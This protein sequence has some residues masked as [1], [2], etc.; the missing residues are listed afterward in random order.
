MDAGWSQSAD[1]VYC[2]AALVFFD[3]AESVHVAVEPM[4]DHR[5]SSCRCDL[6]FSTRGLAGCVAVIVVVVVV[7]VVE[8]IVV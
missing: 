2:G 4:G 5:I 1:A 7:V 3:V 8:L 6:R